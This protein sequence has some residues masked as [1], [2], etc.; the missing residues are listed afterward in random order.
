M[1]FNEEEDVRGKFKIRHSEYCKLR[2]W[3]ILHVS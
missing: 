2:D 1:N 3:I